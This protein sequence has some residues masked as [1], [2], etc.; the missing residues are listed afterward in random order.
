[1]EA[2]SLLWPWYWCVEHSDPPQRSWAAPAG[3]EPEDGDTLLIIAI[4]T[5]RE[6][7]VFFFF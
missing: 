4:K 5:G 3:V 2:G 1:K 6:V 7:G